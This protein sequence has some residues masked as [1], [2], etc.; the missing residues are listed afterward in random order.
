MGIYTIFKL[1]ISIEN[2]DFQRCVQ[3]GQKLVHFEIKIWKYSA[4][5][6][7]KYIGS[8]RFIWGTY[9]ILIHL[10]SSVTQ[11]EAFKK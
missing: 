1:H 11:I 4:I 2:I 10:L 9:N 3:L 6:L 5:K 7:F 8:F